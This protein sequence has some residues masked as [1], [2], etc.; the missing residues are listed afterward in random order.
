VHFK[1]I[2][3]AHEFLKPTIRLLKRQNYYNQIQCRGS[4]LSGNPIDRTCRFFVREAQ[5]FSLCNGKSSE[6]LMALEIPDRP[7]E[8]DCYYPTYDPCGEVRFAL[9]NAYGAGMDLKQGKHFRWVYKVQSI[10]R[11]S[12]QNRN[13]HQPQNV[14]CED[15]PQSFAG[16]FSL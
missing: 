2:N 6:A 7:L 4:R 9:R 16:R 1:R 5:R 11:V 15:A 13:H 3:A 8:D 10:D 14:A 12:K